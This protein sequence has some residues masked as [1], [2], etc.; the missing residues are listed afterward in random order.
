MRAGHAHAGRAKWHFKLSKTLFKLS[1]S[2]RASIL[3]DIFIKSQFL[4][5]KR[6]ERFPSL[7]AT[8]CVVD[9]DG[10]KKRRRRWCIWWYNIGIHCNKSLEVRHY[11]P[12]LKKKRKEPKFGSK[13]FFFSNRRL[14]PCSLLNNVSNDKCHMVQVIFYEFQK[15][16]QVS[17]R[18]QF[19]D[20]WNPPPN[21]PLCGA[22]TI[23]L[24]RA[25]PSSCEPR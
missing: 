6:E 13:Q 3:I 5:T 11:H 1:I 19:D 10:R 24:A 20:P 7:A 4:W 21:E 12:R 17:A 18:R 25:W 8:V 14:R 22:K 23:L 15:D 16:I 2:R 9:D